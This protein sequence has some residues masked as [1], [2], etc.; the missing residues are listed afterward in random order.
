VP[1]VAIFKLDRP[2]HDDADAA[3][4]FVRA[5]NFFS[6]E[7]GGVGRTYFLPEVYLE[8]CAAQD[9]AADV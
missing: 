6:S 2:P 1:R 3:D 8:G 7:G 4:G 9:V 5:A